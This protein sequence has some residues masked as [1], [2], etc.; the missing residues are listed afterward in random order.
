VINKNVRGFKTKADALIRPDP[1][2]VPDSL[3]GKVTAI[4]GGK[5]CLQAGAAI[6]CF[7]MLAAYFYPL[8]RVLKKSGLVMSELGKRA[9]MVFHQRDN[10]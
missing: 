6:V 1:T 5:W 3:L 10:S 2:A 7:S 8:A 9:G 4:T